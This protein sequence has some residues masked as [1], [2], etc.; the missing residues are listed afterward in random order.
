MEPQPPL[1]LPTAGARSL[2]R[3]PQNPQVDRTQLAGGRR[4]QLPTPVGRVSGR[5]EHA[6]ILEDKPEGACVAWTQFSSSPS[7]QL[8]WTSGA[9]PREWARGGGESRGLEARP[10][11]ADQL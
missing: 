11:P 2:P 4:G 6:A 7:P 10:S 8:R 5:G 1:P 3:A 9:L